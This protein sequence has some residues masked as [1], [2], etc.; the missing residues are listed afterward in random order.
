MDNLK[1]DMAGVKRDM[2]D[3]KRDIAEVKRDI[4]DIKVSQGKTQHVAAIASSPDF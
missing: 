1:D 2:A 4:K 3:I